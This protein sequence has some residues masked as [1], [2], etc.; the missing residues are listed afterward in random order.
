MQRGSPGTYLPVN[1]QRVVGVRVSSRGHGKGEV[2][3]AG[4]AE[5]WVCYAHRN[6]TGNGER[7]QSFG[8]AGHDG[9]DPVDVVALLSGVDGRAGDR[10]HDA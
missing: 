2:V 4:A 10:G 9:R 1:M 5:C 8:R 6:R 7:R 3:G